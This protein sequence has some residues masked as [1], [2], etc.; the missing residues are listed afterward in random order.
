M[1]LKRPKETLFDLWPGKRFGNFRFLPLFFVFGAG[2]EFFMINWHVGEVNF[3][4]TFKKRRVEELAQKLLEKEDHK[5][6]RA[7]A[8]F[9][10]EL[11]M[12]QD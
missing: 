3:Y 8:G 10:E 5:A 12:K 9:T 1:K 11:L 2:L 6:N 7:R 4:R